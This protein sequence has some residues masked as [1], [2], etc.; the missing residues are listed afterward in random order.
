MLS[1]NFLQVVHGGPLGCDALLTNRWILAFRQ[2]IM[3][4]FS[5]LTNQH[6]GTTLK[7]I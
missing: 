6:D 2:K 5:G 1:K 3:P 7:T 4:Q